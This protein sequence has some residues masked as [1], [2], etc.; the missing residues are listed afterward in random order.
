MT[1]LTTLRQ[2]KLASDL[3]FHLPEIEDITDKLPKNPK[4]SWL[5]MPLRRQ[6]GSVRSGPRSFS[7]I[8]RIS[9]HHTGV[10][11]TAAG[12]ANYHINKK[13]PTTPDGYGGIAYHIYVNRNHIYQVNDLLALTWHTGS[14]NYDTI[15]IAIEGNFT[16]RSLTNDERQALYGAIITVMEI[17][18]IPV[19]EVKGHGE[20]THNT[21]CPGFDMNQVR[22]D[23]RQ[24]IMEM[25]Y[26]R[27]AEHRA[28][29][30]QELYA[31]VNHLYSIYYNNGQYA[32]DAERK[33]Y[34]LY[35]L[36]EQYELMLPTQKGKTI[37]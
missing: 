24:I 18:G 36:A 6:D 5:T 37:A 17:F 15:G 3:P 33:L 11:G 8:K 25:E 10:E 12:H 13:T 22:N 27:T 9:V 35:Q 19:D 28:I 29:A 21:A 26:R 32:A 4:G 30:I 16:Q 34:T 23:V 20:I 7:D 31:R 2:I 1:Q 14:N